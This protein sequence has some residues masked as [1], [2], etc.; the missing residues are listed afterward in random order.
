MGLF[1]YISDWYKENMAIPKEG[2]NL[3]AQGT[4]QTA[5]QLEPAGKDKFRFESTSIVL[6]F[7][8]E[9]NTMLLKQGGGEFTF[10]K[11]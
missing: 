8:L 11:E 10:T 6:E 1:R 9:I 2:A 5:G 4:D 7:N 3:I